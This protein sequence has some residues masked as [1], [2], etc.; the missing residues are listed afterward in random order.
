MNRGLRF[1]A[2]LTAIILPVLLLAL[3]A[4]AAERF[5][6]ETWMGIYLGKLKVGYAR[7]YSERA[8]FEGKPGY[9][10]ENTSVIKVAMLGSDVEQNLSTVTYLNANYEPVHEI[11]KM[12][13]GG[14]S[15]TVTA[16]F[17]PTEIIAE[18]DSDGKKT[19]KKIPIPPGSKLVGEDS[20]LLTGSAKLKVGD[21]M[22]YKSFDPLMLTL[23]DVR[24]E[25]VR[26]EDLVLDDGTHRCLVIR[27]TT[28]LGNATSW[29]D[30]V[31]NLLKV[32]MDMGFVMVREPK[33][34]AQSSGEYSPSAD[35]AV[36]TSA[37]TKTKIADP[38]KVKYLKVRLGGFTDKSLV[39]NDS[40]QKAT[41]TGGEKP[42]AEYEITA[43][44]FDASKSVTL[45]IKDPAMAERLSEAAYIQPNDMKIKAAS[46]QIVG[47]EK[48]A[49]KAASLIRD[50]VSE[51]MQTNADVGVIRSSTE[52][53]KSRTG[54]CRD[55][56][57]LYTAL[58]R[59]A[60]IPTM[61]VTGMIYWKDG[62]YYHAWAESFVGEWIPMDATLDGAFVDATHLK[63]AE[64]DTMAM[65]KMVKAVGML[66]A[67]I[68]KYK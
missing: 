11:F 47:G 7:L 36:M 5:P 43:R 42:S 52:I 20:T 56:A 21:K 29:Q 8:D 48:D 18:I 31:D 3:A 13:S 34:I 6:N 4:P 55:Y 51:N 53:L 39:L 23:D 50:W 58:A 62:F 33:E 41:Y 19:M 27:S 15:T 28:P 24:I 49:F 61:I 14:V 46:M 66:K 40:R 38:R 67:E 17:T 65:F 63:L 35:L 9:R 59:A 32:E 2:R 16:K 44:D 22:S 1:F 64:G 26:A 10:M 25:V 54:V 57:V 12:S 30:D 45:P 68:V 60:G 37:R